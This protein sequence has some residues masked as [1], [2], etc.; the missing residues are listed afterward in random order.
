MP[1]VILEHSDN[2]TEVVLATGVV[3]RVHDVM[4]ASGLFNAADV[5]TRAYPTHDF[6]VG[7]KGAEGRFLHATIYL[8]EGRPPE[9]KQALSQS[10]YDA[11]IAANL[12]LDSVTVDLRELAKDVYRKN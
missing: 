10:V 8:L 3:R 9:K 11:L 12:G 1:H 4:L 5:K 6:L 7:I 2:T